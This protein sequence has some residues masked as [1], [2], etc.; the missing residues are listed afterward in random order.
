MGSRR[1][2]IRLAG[3]HL[4]VPR[5]D[6]NVNAKDSAIRAVPR[7]NPLLGRSFIKFRRELLDDA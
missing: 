6:A 1:V 3:R 5:R 7:S 2:Q 4:G